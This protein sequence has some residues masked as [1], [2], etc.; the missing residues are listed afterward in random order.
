MESKFIHKI[1]K[2]SRFNQIYIPKELN[3]S[4]DV[5]D[6]VEVKLLKKKVELYYSKNLKKL[7]KFKEKLIKDIFS[8]L[9]HYKEIG[10]VFFVGSFLTKREDY[11]DI[12]I[13]ILS[14]KS[15]RDF[16]TKIYNELVEEFNLKLHIILIEENKFLELLKTNPLIRNMIFCSVSNKKIEEMPEII[17]NKRSIKHILMLPEDVLDVDVDT[18]MLFNAL[19]R[20]IL[21]ESFIKKKDIQ[22]IEIENKIVKLLGSKLFE[23]IKNNLT[24]NKEK[25]DKIKEIIKGKISAILEEIK[26]E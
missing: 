22:P 23:D 25:N 3:E 10:K 8:S 7:S 24:I 15:D 18:K 11:N 1:S 13:L 2:G 26:N 21:M 14:K 5:G 16:E 6:L 9:S 17:I 20:V 19:R 12:D 4:F